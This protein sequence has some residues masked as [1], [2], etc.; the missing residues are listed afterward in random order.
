MRSCSSIPERPGIR[1]SE[2]TSAYGGVVRC[3]RSLRII[4]NP[5]PPSAA[6]ST[7]Q[8]IRVKK[9]RKATRITDSSSMTRTRGG[10]VIPSGAGVARSAGR[11]ILKK[12]TGI[13]RRKQLCE[14]MEKPG[15]SRR[16]FER[17]VRM[18]SGCVPE[19]G[20][21]GAVRRLAEL[22]ER[23]LA[24]LTDALAR[25]THERADLLER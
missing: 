8:P 1:R 7:C 16:A 9:R 23:T 22:L 20:K 14:Q 21:R 12:T 4:C 18:K 15:G 19:S 3:E 25:D 6:S 10:V 13:G 5:L 24:N 11:F 17:V 2:T